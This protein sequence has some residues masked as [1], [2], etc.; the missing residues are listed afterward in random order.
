VVDILGRL[1]AAPTYYEDG[2]GRVKAAPTYY[3]DG[4]SRVST[5]IRE[6]VASEMN[7]SNASRMRS[8]FRTSDVLIGRPA[9]V[10]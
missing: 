8:S 5:L 1:K 2:L 7:C 6:L 9:E 3:L 4:T 10:T